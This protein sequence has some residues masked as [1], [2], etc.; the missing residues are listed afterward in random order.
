MRMTVMESTEP[1]LGDARPDAFSPS[2]D[3]L[4][5]WLHRVRCLCQVHRS[6]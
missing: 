4:S 1:Q 6:T 5:M 2:C 3:K